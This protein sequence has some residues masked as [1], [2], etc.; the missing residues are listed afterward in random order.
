MNKKNTFP[1]I[2]LINFC[3]FKPK[4]SK[5]NFNYNNYLFKEFLYPSDKKDLQF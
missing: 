5:S 2:K 1:P 4:Y 3:N